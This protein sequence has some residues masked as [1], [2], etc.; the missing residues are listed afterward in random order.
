M[1]SIKQQ[2]LFGIEIFYNI[3]NIVLVTFNHINAS[4]VNKTTFLFIKKTY[5]SNFSFFFKLHYVTFLYIKKDPKSIT[6]QV[7]NQSVFKT[8]SL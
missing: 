2:R 5:C 3:I 4:L 6:E 8:I 1:E 7:H